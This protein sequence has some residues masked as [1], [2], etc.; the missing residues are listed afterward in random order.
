[1]PILLTPAGLEGYFK[2]FWTPAPAL[3][4]P[5]RGALGWIYALLYEARPD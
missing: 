1:M 3:T 5:R 2:Q 4:L